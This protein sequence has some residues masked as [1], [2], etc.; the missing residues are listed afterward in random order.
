MGNGRGGGLVLFQ[1]S[2]VNLSV[3]GSLKYFIDFYINKN[4][5]N[6][7]CFMGFYGEPETVKRYEAQ[8]DL[9]GLIHH[10]NIPQIYARDF[11]KITKQGEKLGGALRNHNQMQLF[12]EVID[13]CGF[14]D[15][16]FIGSFFTQSKHFWDGWSIQERLDRGLATNSF[17]LKFPDTQVHH[18]YCDASDHSPLLINLSRLDTPTR[19]KKIAL[20]KCCCLNIDIGK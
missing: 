6:A 20:R 2:S 10:S 7:W 16:G 13:E 11:N 15:L 8:N 12:K 9:R 19:K 14:M 3:E 5:K 4:S 17:F 18:P 1:K